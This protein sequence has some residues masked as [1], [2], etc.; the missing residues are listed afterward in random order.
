MATKDYYKGV[1]IQYKGD[2]T[3]LSKVL[4]QINSEMR[5]SQGAARALD[6]ALKWDGKNVIMAEDVRWEGTET[7]KIPDDYWE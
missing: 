7:L 4:S 1:T 5:Q 2:A 6:A 3:N